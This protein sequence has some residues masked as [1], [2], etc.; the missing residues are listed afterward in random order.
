MMP[1]EDA[2]VQLV[3]TPPITDSHF[4]PYLVN[5]LRS[6]DAALLCF[7][8]SSD[9]AP[10]ETAT[11]MRQFESRKTLLSDA[12]GFSEDDFTIVRIRTLLA[13]T[14]G[15]D[16]GAKDRLDFLREITPLPFEIALVEF[17]RADSREAFRKQVYDLLGVIRVYTKRPGK[18]AEMKDPFTI[19]K[20]G[21]V[22][23]VAY[24]VHRD[25]IDTLKFAKVWGTSAHDGQT[26]GRD[27]VLADKDVVEL[28]A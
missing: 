5:M 8:G 6:A 15:D 9:D 21:N 3:D 24:K 2:S 1:W 23:D 22:E 7:D 19:S 26:V 18:P 14:R 12:T 13:V 25:L 4:E 27:H 11:V 10:E 28:H 17:D 16:P 20:G